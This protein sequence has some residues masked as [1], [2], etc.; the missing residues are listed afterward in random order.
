M[1]PTKNV[2]YS[3]GRC[4][5]NTHTATHGA[6]PPLSCMAREFIHPKLALYIFA[7]VRTVAYIEI[8]PLVISLGAPKIF[9][10]YVVTQNRWFWLA[11]SKELKIK[12]QNNIMNLINVRD[13]LK[14][15]TRGS[16]IQKWLIAITIY[17]IHVR[18][19]R[20]WWF[21]CWRNDN[22]ILMSNAQV[23]VDDEAGSNKLNYISS[24]ICRWLAGWSLAGSWLIVNKHRRSARAQ[25]FCDHTI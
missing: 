16:S 25:L 7:L 11:L 19:Y 23:A 5:N 15:I 21:H 18:F 24:R 8:L 12:H 22:C 14:H 1:V 6:S 20:W 4:W 17:Y 2:T 9:S 3:V 13:G 10:I